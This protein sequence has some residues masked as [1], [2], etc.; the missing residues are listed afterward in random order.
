VRDDVG[1]VVL[2]VVLG[3]VWLWM[4][5]CD[6]CAATEPWEGRALGDGLWVGEPDECCVA[7]GCSFVEPVSV[8]GEDVVV[9]ECLEL[10]DGRGAELLVVLNVL[11]GR[12]AGVAAGDLF[13]GDDVSGVDRRV[14]RDA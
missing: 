4:F 1:G 13:E 12:L 9:V 10:V 8:V 5:E 6:P 7:R 11:D 14:W 2:G 3:V